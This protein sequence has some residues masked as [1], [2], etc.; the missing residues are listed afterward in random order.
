VRRITAADGR[1]WQI[2]VRTPLPRWRR[3]SKRIWRVRGWQAARLAV[4]EVA[5]ELQQGVEAAPDDRLLV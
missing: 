2:R 5:R 3:W 4:D 1:V